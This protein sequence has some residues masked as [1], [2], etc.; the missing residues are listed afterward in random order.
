MRGLRKT[1]QAVLQKCVLCVRARPRRFEQLMGQLPRPRVNPSTAFTHTGVDLCGPFQVLPSQ[2]AKMRITVYACLFVCFATKAV[3]I[4]VVENQSTGAFLAA[5]IRFVSLRG[6][7]EIIYS[8]NGRN[9]VGA[10]RE[11]AELRKVFNTELFQH[12]LVGIA[13][14]QGINFSSFHLGVRILEGSGK[15]I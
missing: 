7:P 5:M 14:E 11:L 1:A 4:E 15:L 12:E 6:R 8:D 10:S 13:A 9:F 3:H 2:R